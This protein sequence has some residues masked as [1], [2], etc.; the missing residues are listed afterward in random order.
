LVVDDDSHDRAWLIDTL[1][2]GGYAVEAAATGTDALR[3]LERRRYDAITLDLM[4]PDMSGWDILRRIREGATNRNS[5][6]VVVSMLADQEVASASPS[7]TFWKS[8]LTVRICSRFSR[9]PAPLRDR[10]RS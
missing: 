5:P 4:L 1:D 9:R 2:K 6:V 3:M 10:R 7:T 8:R